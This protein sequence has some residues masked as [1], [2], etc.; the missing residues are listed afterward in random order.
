MT[1]DPG[2]MDATPRHATFVSM[3]ADVIQGETGVSPA[4]VDQVLGQVAHGAT[5]KEIAEAL[6]V[7]ESYCNTV[8]RLPQNPRSRVSSVPSITSINPVASSG[9]S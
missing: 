3:L 8:C 4:L 2:W 7:S 5:N 6:H 1:I 9:T